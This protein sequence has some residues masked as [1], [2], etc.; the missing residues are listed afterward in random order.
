MPVFLCCHFLAAYVLTLY[1]ARQRLS[2]TELAVISFINKDKMSKRRF[3]D[4]EDVGL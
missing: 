1:I 4:A 3:V 2:L